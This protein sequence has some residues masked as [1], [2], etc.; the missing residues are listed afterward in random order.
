MHLIPTPIKKNQIVFN[1][2]GSAVT[3]ESLME[4]FSQQAVQRYSPGATMFN[5]QG[6]FNVQALRTNALLRKDEWEELDAAV[7]R[8]AAAEMVWIADLVSR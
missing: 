4:Q 1:E 5:A 3:L 2:G 8:I 6:K 7:V